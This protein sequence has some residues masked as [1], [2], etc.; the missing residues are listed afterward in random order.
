MSELLRTSWNRL[1][2]CRCKDTISTLTRFWERGEWEIENRIPTCTL[3]FSPWLATSYLIG[4]I[5]LCASSFWYWLALPTLVCH[6]LE[7]TVF[8]LLL[9]QTMP[10]L[11]ILTV[12][13][14]DYLTAWLISWLPD[15][16][17]CL[18]E[19]FSPCFGFTFR[20]DLLGIVI[21]CLF[22]CLIFYFRTTRH[23]CW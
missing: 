4:L 7:L 18:F 9:I 21:S 14:D 3:T 15:W 12:Y 17:C 8:I 13:L 10:H 23:A 22:V 1:G 2:T 6:Q 16:L 5:C 19:L 11:A 20:L